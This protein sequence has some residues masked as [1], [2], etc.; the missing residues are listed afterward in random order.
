[1]QLQTFDSKTKPEHLGP[2]FW[3]QAYVI[4]LDI[5]SEI[6]IINAYAKY[7]LNEKSS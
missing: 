2:T 7:E 3:E 5:D 6:Y 4:E 1:M